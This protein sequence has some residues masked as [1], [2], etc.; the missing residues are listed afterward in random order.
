M[1]PYWT[2]LFVSLH[3]KTRVRANNFSLEDTKK[4]YKYTTTGTTVANSQVRA[5]YDCSTRP[6]NYNIYYNNYI[7]I[8]GTFA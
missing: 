3:D 5:L 1:D 4:A 7:I 6:T 8:A 2:D